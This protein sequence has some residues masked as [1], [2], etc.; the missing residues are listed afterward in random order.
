MLTWISLFFTSCYAL[1]NGVGK[2][3]AMGWNPYNAFSYVRS[4][5]PIYLVLKVSVVTRSNRSI[6]M[7]RPVSLA[8]VF[9]IEV[10]N[11]SICEF[12][13][14]HTRASQDIHTSDCGWQAKARD[15]NGTFAWDPT[16]I[17]NGIP[18]LS[19]YIHGLGL[20]FGVYS[21]GQVLHA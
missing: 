19:S 6:E 3:P 7:L 16:I 12:Y 15:T 17:P 21:D 10:M 13:V 14:I 1:N 18:A 9:A 4:P 5:R 8:S 20:K 2:T 11:T